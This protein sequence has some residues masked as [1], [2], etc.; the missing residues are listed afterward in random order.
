MGLIIS[1]KD[2]IKWIEGERRRQ[3]WYLALSVISFVLMIYAF[4]M[5]II[6]QNLFDPTYWMAFLF[7][8]L[9]FMVSSLMYVKSKKYLLIIDELLENRRHGSTAGLKN[10]FKKK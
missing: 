1:S 2:E 5:R 10:L 9:A 4:A 8:F 3:A 6:P 7:A